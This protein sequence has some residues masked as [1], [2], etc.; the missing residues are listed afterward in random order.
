MMKKPL[1][2]T[3]F[4]AAVLLAGGTAQAYWVW[5]PD[6]GKW[7]NPK[8]SSKD[9]PQEQFNWAMQFYNEKNWDRAIDE[10]EKLPQAFPNSKLAAEGVYFTGLC[11][12]AKND[13]A[14]AAD[15]YK[16]LVDRYPY[17]DRIKDAVTREFE[18]AGRFAK[19]GKIKVLGVPALAGQ[20]KALEIYK[21]I[22][23]NAPFGTIGDQAQF[24]IGELYQAQ[25]EFEEAQKAFQAVVDEY[26][27]SPLVPKARY[28]IAQCSLLASKRS[29]YSEASAERAIEDFQG[30]KQ[31]FP[32]D[33]QTLDADASIKILRAKKAQTSYETA[34]FYEKNDKL[35]SAMV[36]YR[37]IVDKFGDTPYGEKAKKRIDELSKRE[38][39]PPGKPWFKIW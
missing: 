5:S 32:A 38:N 16:K 8:S 24:K 21:H 13:D 37:E 14:K 17:S 34:E 36:Y 11:W 7:T 6:L 19:G 23:R 30:F 33:A 27:N 10:F 9:D 2:I 39:T 15:A 25:S 31:N 29:Q 35:K 4:L 26:P 28:Q 18:I 12:E 22:I 3:L 1:F 20:E